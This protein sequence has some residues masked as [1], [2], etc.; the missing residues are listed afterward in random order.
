ME[1]SQIHSMRSNL[2]S[3]T[4]TR[5]RQYK[6]ENYR[7]ISLMNIDAEIIIKILANQIQQYMKGSYTLIYWD[8]FQGHKNGQYSQI[9]QCNSWH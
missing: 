2:V 7:P 6:K 4:K 8:L 9:N 3:D 5:Q 1:H